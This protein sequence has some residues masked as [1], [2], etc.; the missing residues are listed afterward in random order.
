MPLLLYIYLATEI[1]AP[2]LGAFVILNAILFLGKLVPMLEGIFSL[3]IGAADF[4]RLLAYLAPNMLLFSIPMA[5]M[6]GVIICF[7]RLN[8][9][10]EI[11]ALKASGISLYRM[12]PPVIAVA[13][14]TTALTGL[15]SI[16]FIPSGTVDLQ[17]LLFR[18]AKEKIDKGMREKQ[19]SQSLSDVVLYVDHVNPKTKG[20]EGVYISDLRDRTAPLTVVARRGRL[21]AHP[22]QMQITLDLADGTMHRAMGELT[23]TIRFDK[24]QLNVPVQAPR[25]VLGETTEGRDTGGMTQGELLAGAAK[26]GTDNP[27]GA[28]LMVEFHKRLALPVGCFLLTLLGVPLGLIVRP[29]RRSLGLPLGLG[30]FI[31]YYILITTAKGLS[32]NTALPVGPTMWTPNLLFGGLTLFLLRSA[33]REKQGR[34][35]EYVL[36]CWR[37]LWAHL[38]FTGGTGR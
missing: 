37:R 2:F 24:Y 16:R 5:S 26:L 28:S 22:A 12:L 33:A 20:W 4:T 3:G 34:F 32:E 38:P 29:G 23:Q 10:N 19:F 25:K 13:L 1:L 27:Q 7:T 30:L 6:M 8:A 31:L 11:I 17:K 36:D 35:V 21:Q 18:V 15:V 14:L 9:D